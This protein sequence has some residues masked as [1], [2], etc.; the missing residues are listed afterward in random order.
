MPPFYRGQ[1]LIAHIDGWKKRIVAG[2]D[3][4]DHLFERKS[5]NGP[6]PRL[7]SDDAKE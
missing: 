6:Y 3:S 7:I 5:K 2:S 1:Q 4:L